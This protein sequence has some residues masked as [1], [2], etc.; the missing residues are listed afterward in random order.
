MPIVVYHD[1]GVAAAVASGLSGLAEGYDRASAPTDQFM[2]QGFANANAAA[3]ARTSQI[4][5]SVAQDAINANRQNEILARQ[6]AMIGERRKQ[7]EPIMQRMKLHKPPN[8][9]DE[10]IDIATDAWA[11]GDEQTAYR[12]L[13]GDPAMHAMIAQRDAAA[14]AAADR[15][16]E[17]ER[18]N[19][20]TESIGNRR[21]DS[22]LAHDD[23]MKKYRDAVSGLRANQRDVSAAK[24]ALEAAKAIAEAN[25]NVALGL[26]NPP[27]DK[28]D[29]EAA[30]LFNEDRQR[31]LDAARHLQSISGGQD[32]IPKAAPKPVQ[33]QPVPQAGSVGVFDRLGGGIADAWGALTGSV[34]SSSPPFA[35]PNTLPAQ[36]APRSAP[37]PQP[38][39]TL[40]NPIQ[41]QIDA[42][43]DKMESEQG[44]PLTDQEIRFIIEHLTPKGK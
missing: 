4:G 21:I 3:N 33:Y 8:V 19:R 7:I 31:Y 29:A 13:T 41:S 32:E 10:H 36:P 37:T 6:Q 28:N 22:T 24:S 38:Q 26:W 12:L 2:Y 16:T 17:M 39:S 15:V 5:H 18:H 1:P 43:I 27:K 23:A 30:A 20:A 44:R 11:N 42:A 34:K 40:P 35:Q 14:K 9:T 25:G